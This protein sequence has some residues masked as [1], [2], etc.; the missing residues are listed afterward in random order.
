MRA[1][2]LLADQILEIARRTG[3][4]QALVT[5]HFHQGQSRFFLGDPAAARHHYLQAI[6]QYREED[7]RGIPDDHGVNSLA[8][9]NHADWLLGYPDQALRHRDGASSVARRLNKPFG[10]AYAE[11][12]VAM[13]DGF[14][15][16]FE[17]ALSASQEVERLSTELGF[18]L[19]RAA[20]KII[21]PWARSQLGETNGAV[22]TIREGLAE[23]DALGFYL[24]RG[25]L[26]C[27]LGETQ[28]LTGAVDEALVT[29]ELALETNLDELIYRPYVLRQRGELHLKIGEPELA[30]ADFR[31]AIALAQK[32][33][34]KSWELRATTSL[35]RL[36]RNTNRRD[37]A[38][39]MLADIYNW[40]TEG[41]DT[42][43]LKEAKALLDELGK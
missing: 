27:L 13:T 38:R 14:R 39:A 25:F 30:E 7:F 5:A 40:F 8:F 10:L 16:D 34:A 9:K 35:A 18:P 20:T 22:S 3:S 15:R 32:M 43:D 37:E 17:R 4:P 24:A 36:L 2:Q 42:R 11:F 28:A 1:A 19:Y 12:I 33:S 41:F 23:L 6:E 21:T 26:R 29:V 31:D